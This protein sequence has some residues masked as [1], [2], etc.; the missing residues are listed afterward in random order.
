MSARFR[1]MD[2]TRP[3][4]AD[5][6]FLPGEGQ[7]LSGTWLSHMFYDGLYYLDI[8]L[9]TPQHVHDKPTADRTTISCPG[10]LQVGLHDSDTMS[11]LPT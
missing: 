4:F 9:A 2:T 8:Q 10:K 5:I 7:L 3:I 11:Y 1:V 6:Y